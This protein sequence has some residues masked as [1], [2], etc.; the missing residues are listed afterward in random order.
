MA[1]IKKL[2]DQDML[3]RIVLK[4]FEFPKEEFRTRYCIEATRNITDKD[5]LIFIAQSSDEY[6]IRIAAIGN[7]NLKDE[8]ILMDFAKYDESHEVRM[9]ALNM[10]DNQEMFIDL[11]FHDDSSRVREYAASRINSKNVLRELMKNYGIGHERFEEICKMSRYKQLQLI[12]DE[13]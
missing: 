2:T 3:K 5:F 10:L 7:T 12:K 1:A 9:V 8:E 6:Q 4:A 11:A 13:K